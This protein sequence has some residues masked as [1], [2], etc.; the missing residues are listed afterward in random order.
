MLLIFRTLRENVNTARLAAAIRAGGNVLAALPLEVLDM[1]LRTEL[2]RLFRDTYEQ[3][4]DAAAKKLKAR[5]VGKDITFETQVD[6]WAFDVV[7]D[8]GL[9][10]L[11]ERGAARVVQITE[12]TRKAIR[13]ALVEMSMQGVPAAT[14]AKRVKELVGLTE[15]H[16]QAVQNLRA[17]LI[18]EGV[19]PARV[20]ALAA[21]KANEL[22]NW[23][24]LTIARTETIAALA[25]GQRESWEQAASEG[26]FE[27]QT[28][29]QAW[30]TSSDEGV[31]DICD[32]MNGQEVPYGQPFTTGDGD[33][34]YDPPAHPRC[35]CVVDLV[36]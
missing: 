18:D 29:M 2:G 7:N 22:L 23:R 25:A 32:P 20:E 24:A 1:R 30:S 5:L 31:C 13:A 3:A 14:Q 15:A 26:L 27:P 19:A 16:A 34:V 11:Q 33:D 9:R 4:G 12:E 10:V 36:L 35:R 17:K 8:R 6:Q 21:R 28:A